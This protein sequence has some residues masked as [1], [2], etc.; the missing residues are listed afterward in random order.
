MI[1]KSLV[2][3]LKNTINIKPYLD[4]SVQTSNVVRDKILEIAAL[5]IGF[6]EGF[7]QANDCLA[8]Q[9][10]VELQFSTDEF[11]KYLDKVTSLELKI[12]AIQSGTFKQETKDK[13]I[14]YC[15]LRS[16]F[17]LKSR[18]NTTN[19]LL[20]LLKQETEKVYRSLGEL[21]N[22]DINVVEK[23]DDRN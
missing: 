8:S 5:K 16:D 23:P 17:D 21:P 10:G 3:K 11:V 22:K 15:L 4:A 1:K 2:K 7:K 18:S 20:E 13:L 12:L 19:P 14:Q 9:L 6:I